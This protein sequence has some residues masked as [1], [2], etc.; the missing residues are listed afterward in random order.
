MERIRYMIL[1]RN[2]LNSLTTVY[3]IT[4]PVAIIVLLLIVSTMY[5]QLSTI[6][7]MDNKHF[8]LSTQ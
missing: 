7:E 6:L 8:I 1:I 2:I 5:F 3:H 4:I